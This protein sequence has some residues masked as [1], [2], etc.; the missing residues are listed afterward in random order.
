MKSDSVRIIF[1]STWPQRTANDDIRVHRDDLRN[2]DL[3]TRDH[4]IRGHSHY[5]SHDRSWDSDEHYR[6]S[7]SRICIHGRN[8]HSSLCSRHDHRRIRVLHDR[9]HDLHIH[10][11]WPDDVSW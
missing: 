2:H 5:H 9:N 11:V 4:R 1:C 10:S 7:S 6:R 8:H 3:R